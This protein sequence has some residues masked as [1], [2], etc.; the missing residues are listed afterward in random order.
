MLQNSYIVALVIVSAIAL[1]ITGMS[2]YLLTGRG[3]SLVAGFNT[4]SE[5]E[6]A[7]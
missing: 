6:K 5:E 7:A 1:A 4:M 2:V 3:G